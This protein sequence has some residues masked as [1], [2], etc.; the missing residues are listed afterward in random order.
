M[1]LITLK[2]VAK[3]Y[4]MGE[5]VVHALKNVDL[6][7]DKAEFVSI[8]GPSGS[9]KTTLLNLIGTLDRIT[10]GTLCFDGQ[11]LEMCDDNGLTEIRN[12]KIGF[13]FQRFNLIPVMSALE[14]VMLPL[15][16]R[17]EFFMTA[18]KK[19]MKRL[20]DV[21]LEKVVHH[22]PDKMSG[23]QQQ[24]V[25]IARA[26]VTDPSLVIADEP[27]ANVDTKTSQMLISLMRDLNR[28]DRTT[29]IFS[30]HDQRLLDSVDRMI[31]LKDG[32]IQ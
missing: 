17:G 23:G 20:E 8:Y 32:V 2:G 9:G 18:R 19:A 31:N 15:Q 13:V 26:L 22:R 21:G 16:L 3:D 10:S 5:S 25:A 27:T 28:N 30:T 12:E 24:R 14:N 11:D 1:P 7:I 6:V 29:F 4:P